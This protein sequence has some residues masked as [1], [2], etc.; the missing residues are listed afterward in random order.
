MERERT[1]P[2]WLERIATIGGLL[3]ESAGILQLAYDAK[4]GNPLQKT[5]GVVTD[6]PRLMLEK[7]YGPPKALEDFATQKETWGYGAI[8]T[9]LLK[10]AA[11]GRRGEIGADCGC[12]IGTN[13]AAIKSILGLSRLTALDI[14]EDYIA[15]ARR[16][17]GAE[18]VDF[19]V[20]EACDWLQDEA[21]ALGLDTVVC[22][23]L[24]H[25]L[26]DPEE[27]LKLVMERNEKTFFFAWEPG[28][29]FY[30]FLIT[31]LDLLTGVLP[32]LLKS[33]EEF[34]IAI[35]LFRATRATPCSGF[36]KKDEVWKEVEAL[37]LQ[38]YEIAVHLAGIPFPGF[39]VVST[40]R[41]TLASL[42]LTLKGR[43]PIRLTVV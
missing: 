27:L 13:T 42:D 26:P 37:G 16:H 6:F 31:H 21:L 10:I 33:T 34:E 29:S 24:L 14:N 5:W 25:Y 1:L 12:G 22:F 3:L 8:P 36:T 39:V 40:S 9:T 41:P 20:A 7:N 4:Q 11:D 32:K 28:R 17:N 35:Q 15:Y 19:I 2:N 18:G 43:L 30:N 23:G 38:V